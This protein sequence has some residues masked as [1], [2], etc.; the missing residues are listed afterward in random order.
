MENRRSG[1]RPSR[2]SI[3]AEF[4]ARARDAGSAREIIDLLSSVEPI[5]RQGPGLEALIETLMY[6]AR[7][8]NED[9]GDAGSAIILWKE[10]F[11]LGSQETRKRVVATMIS[12]A[13]KRSVSS[14]DA[15]THCGWNV[16][17]RPN[18]Y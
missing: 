9:L 16:N 17:C 8:F 14:E 6:G 11:G 15:V 10:V 4:R 7:H 13:R 3:L 2:P 12:V 1:A 5:S 18:P